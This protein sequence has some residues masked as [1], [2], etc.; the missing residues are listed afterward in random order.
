MPTRN[1]AF[2]QAKFATNAQ[3]DHAKRSLLEARGL[4][5]IVVWEC[6]TT[7][8]DMLATK[9]EP[10]LEMARPSSVHAGRDTWVER[11]KIDEIPPS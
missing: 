3:R 8:P 9:L 7:D 10:V 11:S 6:E 5:V 1:Q 4:E 2:W